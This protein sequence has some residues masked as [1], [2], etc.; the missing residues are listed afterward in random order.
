MDING[1]SRAPLN[2]EDSNPGS[3][4]Y[5]PGGVGRNIAENLHRL[6]VKVRFI[7]VIGDDPGGEFIKNSSIRLGLNIEHSLFLKNSGP[8]TS[9]YIAL[10][11]NN[12]ELKI[13]LADM[14][15]MEQMTIEYLE[16]KAS[17]IGESDIVVMDTNLPES[18]FRK[19]C[20]SPFLSPFF[21]DG[22]SARKVSKAAKHIGHFDTLKLGR[23][24]ASVLS[25]VEIPER[26][27]PVFMERLEE[28][29]GNLLKRGVH[30]VFI[31]LGKDGVFT[32]A[33]NRVFYRP[34]QYITPVN[35]SGGGDAFMA[36]IVYGTLN[37][38]DDDKIVS[39]SLAMARITVQSKQTVSSEIGPE[40]AEKIMAN[41]EQGA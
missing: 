29:A 38:W 36:G 28:A 26:N 17:I 8:V 23:M 27:S 5:C 11:D 35:T 32:A 22:V 18:I 21:L 4:E 16:S 15:I 30:R 7:G 1:F 19:W 33:G 31:T 10:M 13:G 3:V 25:G 40:F 37:N 2:L 12:G 6:G 39:F 20:Q 9:V 34:V 24:E 41:G 14:D